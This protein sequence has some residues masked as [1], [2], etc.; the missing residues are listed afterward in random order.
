MIYFKRFS[1][2]AF[3]EPNNYGINVIKF[4][5][6]LDEIHESTTKASIPF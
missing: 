3:K 1:E 6:I 2:V 5:S 4:V